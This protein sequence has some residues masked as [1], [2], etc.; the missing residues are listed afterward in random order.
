MISSLSAL[1]IIATFPFCLLAPLKAKSPIFSFFLGDFLKAFPA[2]HFYGELAVKISFKNVNLLNLEFSPSVSGTLPLNINKL[3]SVFIFKPLISLKS[4][5]RG[6]R[7]TSFS[8]DSS[9]LV[10]MVEAGTKS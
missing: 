4:N 1:A 6:A 3:Y 5:S 10:L 8:V 2:L 7:V 9:F